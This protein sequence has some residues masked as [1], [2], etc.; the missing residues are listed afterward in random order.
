MELK[1]LE[2]AIIGFTGGLGDHEYVLERGEVTSIGYFAK[3]ENL[4]T[5]IQVKE[6]LESKNEELTL[7]EL[8]EKTVIQMTKL[9]LKQRKELIEELS[10]D[11]KQLM[12]ILGLNGLA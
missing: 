7:I 10:H 3:N 9:T 4:Y 8:Q 2:P 1:E 12:E 11:T 6:L 5:E